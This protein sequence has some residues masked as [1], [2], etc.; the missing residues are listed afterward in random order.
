[1]IYTETDRQLFIQVQKI[2]ETF[3]SD[4]NGVLDKGEMRQFVEQFIT[5]ATGEDNQFSD[6]EFGRVFRE[7]DQDGDGTVDP[8][9]MFVFIKHLFTI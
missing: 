8:M 7:L 3:D 9:E 2:W 5:Y 6:E 4:G 1:M